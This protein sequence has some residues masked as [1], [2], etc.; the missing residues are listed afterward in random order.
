MIGKNMFSKTVCISSK[1]FDEIKIGMGKD[2]VLIAGPCA[3]SR[4][5][6]MRLAE[7]IGKFAANWAL[8]GYSRHVMIKIAGLRQIV[9]T[10][11]VGGGFA[12]IN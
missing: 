3:I 6:S 8:D 5:H 9:F 11:L 2:L 12:Y 1:H 10:E 7:S 4:D